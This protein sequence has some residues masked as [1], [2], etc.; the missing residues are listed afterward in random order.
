[1]KRRVV[2]VIALLLGLLPFGQAVA[3]ASGGE[4]LTSEVMLDRYANAKALYDAGQ[5]RASFPIFLQLAKAGFPQAKMSLAYQYE[6]GQGVFPNPNQAKYWYQSAADDGLPAAVIALG[7]NYREGHLVRRNPVLSYAL[8]L[9]ASKLSPGKAT[10]ALAEAVAEMLSPEQKRLGRQLA[11]RM[12]PGHG[13][14]SRTIV[15]AQKIGRP[16]L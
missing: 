9:T 1:M 4:K 13:A 14:I 15:Q 7:L 11:N 3:D 12:K 10:M 5:Y 16:I 6:R 8:F 2:C